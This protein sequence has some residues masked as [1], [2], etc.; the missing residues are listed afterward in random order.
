MSTSLFIDLDKDFT[1]TESVIAD[2]AYIMKQRDA[3]TADF[4]K[5]F[6]EESRM[7]NRSIMCKILASMPIF[8]NSQQEIKNYF[9]YVLENCKDDSELT[10]CF[11]LVS[12][13]I[14]ED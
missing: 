8:L 12:E 9:D 4:A 1:K 11:K 10:A 7:V 2:N 3:V 14:D 6:A 13:I 5:I